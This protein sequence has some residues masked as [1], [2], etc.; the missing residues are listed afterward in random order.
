MATRAVAAL[1]RNR[2]IILWE[3]A[4]RD[5]KMVG[6]KNADTASADTTRIADGHRESDGGRNRA[7][8]PS[9]PTSS[10]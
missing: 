1:I 5:R 3:D 10:S 6:A 2:K 4:P 8:P 7:G 9:L